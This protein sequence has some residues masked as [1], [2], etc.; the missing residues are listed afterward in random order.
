MSTAGS[1]R[2]GPVQQTA[3][4]E[5]SGSSGSAGAD[6]H[7]ERRMDL[8]FDVRVRQLADDIILA[9]RR[10]IAEMDWLIRDIEENGPATT[11]EVAAD[12]PVP[13]FEL[14]LWAPAKD[15]R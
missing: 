13:E 14:D 6:Q 8:V 12:G 5:S 2:T 10:E 4:A 1:D 15:T 11:P 7:R 9:Q 3:P